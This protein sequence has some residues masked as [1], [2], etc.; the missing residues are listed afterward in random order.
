MKKFE[1]A[2]DIF[3]GIGFGVSYMFIVLV[4]GKLL[5]LLFNA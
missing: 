1:I 2:R 4:I 3:A 5:Y